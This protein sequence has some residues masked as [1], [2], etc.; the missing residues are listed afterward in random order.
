[1]EA[2]LTSIRKFGDALTLWLSIVN[3]FA[4]KFEAENSKFKKDVFLKACGVDV[5]G[6][7]L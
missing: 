3:N 2:R 4:D 5:D 1:M 7:L 6:S